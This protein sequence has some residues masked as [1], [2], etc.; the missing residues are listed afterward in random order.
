M[1]YDEEYVQTSLGEI[2]TKI[3][4]G[5]TPRGG[6]KVYVSSGVSQIR[7]QNVLDYSFSEQG[8]V[9]I[10]DN[11]AALL[12]NVTVQPNDV[13]I[14]ITG[15]SVTRACIVP[16][17]VL[18]ARVNQH[19]AIIRAKNDKADSHFLLYILQYQKDLL[20][21]L[22]S[23]GATRKAITKAMLCDLQLLLP[24]LPEQR[25]IAATLA[26]LDAKIELNNRMNKILEEMAQAIFKSWFV[27]FEPFQDGE[28]VDSELGSIPKGWEVM[29]F[30]DIFS[31]QEGPGI[32]NWQYV[33]ENGTKFINIRCIK[34]GDLSL[35]TANMIS[36]DEAFDK[37]SHFLLN[38]GD[39]VIS[40]SGTLGRSAIVRKEHLPLCL[41]TSVMRFTTKRSSFDFSF[42]IGYLTSS[43]FMEHML[44]KATGS[45]QENF[46][47]IHIR[48]IKIVVPSEEV[49]GKYHKLVNPL[50]TKRTGYLSENQ[51][52]KI[53]RNS[54]LPKLMSG[55][56]HVPMEV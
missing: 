18:P 16:D 7:S 39:V 22:S 50:T 46:G 34:D 51:V 26:C 44:T 32:R 11:S 19:V 24:S 27:D 2:C 29:T 55:E 40:T 56:I 20:L 13:L 3:G 47:P 41:N 15:D 10:D 14:N 53:V 31:Y 5:A 23:S 48:Q 37:Y 42:L 9:H 21:T 52:L 45:V 35:E 30:P 25:A 54:L 6:D 8:L 17:W 43:I 49:S 12:N 38:E 33:S 36:T 1:K 4:S 28:F